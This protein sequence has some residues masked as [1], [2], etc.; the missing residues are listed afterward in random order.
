MESNENEEKQPDEL[1]QFHAMDR[2]KIVDKTESE[3][4]ILNIRG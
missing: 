1:V 3:E 4:D 2:I